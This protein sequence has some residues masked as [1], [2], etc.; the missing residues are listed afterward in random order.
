MGET[1]SRHTPTSDICDISISGSGQNRAGT[2]LQ[3][4]SRN[5][6]AVLVS[7]LE[8][9]PAGV[10]RLS[11]IFFVELHACQLLPDDRREIKREEIPGPHRHSHDLRHTFRRLGF[12]IV[13]FP[14]KK[15]TLM[16]E[17]FG[18]EVEG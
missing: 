2:N 7:K 14:T 3:L 6:L 15:E 5:H 1:E 12:R 11:E 10:V 4:R 18:F 17:G 9:T 8:R 16:G 13:I